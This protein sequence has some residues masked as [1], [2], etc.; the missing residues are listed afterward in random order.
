[1]KNIRGPFSTNLYEAF[2]VLR[3]QFGH[4]QSYHL[5]LVITIIKWVTLNGKYMC[6]K[7]DIDRILEDE[8]NAFFTLNNE[9]E[10]FESLNPKF[11]GVLTGL[12]DKA[13]IYKDAAT[14]K[15]IKKVFRLIDSLGFVSADEVRKF[16]NHLVAYENLQSNSNETPEII[17]KIIVGLME[18]EAIKDFA[19]FCPGVSGTAVEIY[20]VLRARGVIGEAFYYGEE[21]KTINCLLSK[22][23]MLVNEVDDFEIVNKNVL[24]YK[25]VDGGKRFD[26]I[27]CDIPQVMGLSK[28]K[29][30]K[31]PRLK[32]GLPPR[33]T[34]DW[35]FAQ[36]CI[37]YLKPTGVAIIVGTKGTLV[38]SS[39]DSIRRGI[40]ND[41]LVECVITLPDNLYGKSN[42]GTEMIIF[43]R[44]KSLERKDKILFVDASKNSCRL[45]KN[46]HSIDKEGIERI[47]NTYKNGFEERGFSKFV[48]L[49]KL[50][51][52]DF[53]LNP[54]EYLSFDE[55][56]DTL[57]NSIPLKEIADVASGVQISKK[58]LEA[59]SAEPQT[60]YYLNIKDINEG[61]INYDETSRLTYKKS[62]WIGRYDL[63]PGDI[64]ITTKGWAIKVAIVEDLKPAFISGNLTRV[65]VYPEKYN[66]YVLFEFLQSEIGMKMLEGL[67]TGTTIKL[68]NNAQLE[69]LE[70]PTFDMDFLN[71]KGW[72][73]KE[74]KA[75]YERTIAKATKEFNEKREE[76]IRSLGWKVNRK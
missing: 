65:R 12:V 43:N 37:Y 10:R 6:S 28:D 23:L 53:R 20:E 29:I 26:L 72:E 75:Q 31:D 19:V 34:A 30:K 16:I 17:N 22:L 4:Q 69:R 48:S 55:I 3:G 18:L 71:Q 14:D 39:E 59:L 15:G 63:E 38:R 36:N 7:I 27:V 76:L 67:Q 66:P 33:S 13:Y 54:L 70:V 40:V 61:K 8:R 21:I 46:Q 1:M 5:I 60:H 41:D 24:E 68:L 57:T 47:I 9:L 73:I 49:E 45:N 64:V 51:E 50:A 58:D 2:N 25:E 52:Y 32:Y 42:I 44:H 11:K 74:S 35:I 56:K 62:D